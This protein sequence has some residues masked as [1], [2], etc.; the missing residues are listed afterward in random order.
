MSRAPIA[1]PV[2][3]HRLIHIQ[4]HSACKSV[5]SL[6]GFPKIYSDWLTCILLW[7][8]KPIL[9]YLNKHEETLPSLTWRAS[10]TRHTDISF[11][12]DCCT[13]R[14]FKMWGILCL[15]QRLQ[16]VQC[17]LTLD[18]KQSRNP[19][20]PWVTMVLSATLS[21]DSHLLRIFGTQ[22]LR[23]SQLISVKH[24]KTITLVS[25]HPLLPQM[26]LRTRTICSLAFVMPLILRSIWWL[27]PHYCPVLKLGACAVLGTS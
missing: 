18:V 9:S 20:C 10:P 3:P 1:S 19:H 5:Q 11:S 25:K 21:A 4:T 23:T 16:T 17:S 26:L 7:R 12:G 15:F 24:T 6:C 27:T 8:S 22:P 2:R 13:V 14:I